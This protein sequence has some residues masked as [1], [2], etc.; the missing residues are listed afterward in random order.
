MRGKLLRV[1]G[2]LKAAA[3]H[4]GAAQR[5]LGQSYAHDQQRVVAQ[6]SLNAS[7]KAVQDKYSD[8]VY[9]AIKPAELPR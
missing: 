2:H 3:F 8:A 5:L 7:I 9:N 4:L 1:L 6:V